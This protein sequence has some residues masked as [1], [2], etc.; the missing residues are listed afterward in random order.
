MAVVG[1]PKEAV[2]EI[3]RLLGE[4]APSPSTEML[5]A[6]DKAFDAGEFSASDA[7][8]KCSEYMIVPPA[9]DWGL[10]EPHF[11][12]HLGAEE[13]AADPALVRDKTAQLVRA[14]AYWIRRARYPDGD[15]MIEGWR[16]GP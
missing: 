2:A 9:V 16:K 5:D 12:R 8:Y 3:A 11:Q 1:G 7:L 15:W 13:V 6:Y 14:G 10:G 4:A